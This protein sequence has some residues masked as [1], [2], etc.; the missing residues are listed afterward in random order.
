MSEAEIIVGLTEAKCAVERL[1]E[2]ANS[3]GW[4]GVENSKLLDEFLRGYIDDLKS[5][6][7]EANA[8]LQVRSDAG[9]RAEADN[10]IIREISL[11]TGDDF[12]EDLDIRV[13]FDK[14]QSFTATE[15]ACHEKLSRIY[16]IAHSHDRAASCYHVHENW[17]KE[18]R[19]AIAAR[20]K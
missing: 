19:A 4:D 16:R 7:A 5:E 9:A 11:L 18:V 13:A 20:S 15:L 10:A 2:L 14:K 8:A 12:C 3:L 6:L 1:A 17:R